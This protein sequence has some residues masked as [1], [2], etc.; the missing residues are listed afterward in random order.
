MPIIKQTHRIQFEQLPKIY[1]SNHS[2]KQNV[3]R[4]SLAVQL[5]GASGLDGT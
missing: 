2:P 5:Y 3:L 1:I 4:N